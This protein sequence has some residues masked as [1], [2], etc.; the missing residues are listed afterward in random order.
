LFGRAALGFLL[1][2]DLTPLRF[3][4]AAHRVDA[5][6]LESVTI[7]VPESHERSAPNGIRLASSHRA[8]LY[9]AQSW[10]GEK[11]NASFAPLLPFRNWVLTYKDD[12][13]GAADQPILPGLRL[14]RDQGQ[15]GVAVRRRH[16]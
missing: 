4:R 15:H 12:A 5:D 3:N 7:R 11:L 8:E 13:G 10:S 6:Q 9:A 2:R 14:R 16:S 1:F